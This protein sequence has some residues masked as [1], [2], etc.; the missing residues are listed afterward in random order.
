MKMKDMR[1]LFEKVTENYFEECFTQ[2]ISEQDHFYYEMHHDT[3][4]M[5]KIKSRDVAKYLKD[6]WINGTRFIYELDKYFNEY[7][8]GYEFINELTDMFDIIAEDNRYFCFWG[9]LEDKLEE[10]GYKLKY[11]SVPITVNYGDDALFGGTYE[12]D[13]R[14]Y[15]TLERIK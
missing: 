10:L 12:T 7:E 15:Y 3:E 1:E 8:I 2:E 4:H 14:V 5:A 6:S 11:H 9:E 13:M